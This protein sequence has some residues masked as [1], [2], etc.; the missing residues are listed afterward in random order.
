M[1]T[2]EKVSRINRKVRMLRQA[3]GLY[4][5]A[6][7]AEAVG[8]VEQASQLRGRA[9]GLEWSARDAMERRSRE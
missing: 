2:G 1:T 5:G 9:A 4:V 6:D 3:E 8:D 7:R